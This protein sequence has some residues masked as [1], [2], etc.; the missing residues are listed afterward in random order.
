VSLNEDEARKIAHAIA[1][2]HAYEKHASNVSE[3]GELLTQSSFESL[4]L[5]T[6]LNPAKSRQLEMGRTVF[7]NA[8]EGLLVIVSPG[9]PD[10][11][12]AYWPA[13]GIDGYTIVR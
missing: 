1:F 7:W 4:V 11:G 3:S 12:I 9:D 10:M 13:K 6:L 8:N 2:G 5:E